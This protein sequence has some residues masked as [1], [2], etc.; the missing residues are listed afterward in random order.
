M[1]LQTHLDFL[2]VLVNQSTEDEHELSS[3]HTVAGFQAVSGDKIARSINT[4][5][6]GK[7][8]KEILLLAAAHYLLAAD[9]ITKE[10]EKH[11]ANIYVNTKA[12]K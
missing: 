4:D 8:A 9:K 1:D 3:Y 10:Q 12:L 6:S 2:R 11:N 7:T 5:T